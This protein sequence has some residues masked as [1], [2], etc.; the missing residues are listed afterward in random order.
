MFKALK[1]A[2]ILHIQ[3]PNNITYYNNYISK[4]YKLNIYNL[5][6]T[7]E[8]FANKLLTIFVRQLIIF[9]LYHLYARILILNQSLYQIYI[10][11]HH[12]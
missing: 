9:K 4:Y 1:I 2:L 12:L 6:Q 7:Y 10:S 3:K 11:K 8:S 5:F